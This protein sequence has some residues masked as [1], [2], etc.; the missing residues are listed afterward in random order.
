MKKF[1]VL[2]LSLL[3]GV[4]SVFAQTD[5]QTR[6]IASG[7]K[8]KI[9]GVVVSKDADKIVVRDVTGVD[10]SVAL[11][12]STSIKTKGGFFGGSKTTPNQA[13]VRGLNLEVEGRGDGTNLVAEKVRF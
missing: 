9:Q 8:M 2:L 11:T 12:P 4:A 6:S 1:P 10:T 13:I 7:Q 5:N 3:L